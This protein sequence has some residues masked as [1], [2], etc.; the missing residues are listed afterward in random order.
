MDHW[1]WQDDAY[2]RAWSTILMTVNH[3]DEKV[4]IHKELIE[5]KRGQSLLSL[6]GW[7]KM[8]GRRWT[9]QKTRTFLNLLK[10][11]RMIELEG[12]RKTTR[13][14][15]CNYEYYQGSQQTNNRQITDIQQTD[16]RQITSNNKLKNEKND[17]NEKKEYISLP[18]EKKYN[19][20]IVLFNSITNR[21]YRG[22][23]SSRNHFAARIKDGYTIDDIRIAIT[24]AS[25]DE[26]HRET[27]YKYLTP[28]YILRSNKIEQ[29]L[30]VGKVKVNDKTETERMLEQMR[31]AEEAAKRMERMSQ[32]KKITEIIEQ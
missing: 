10:Q 12:L 1:I 19:D 30:Q 15:V 24:A 27:N 23:R 9:V 25:R 18:I 28:E 13:L 22:D 17:K 5:C 2:Y 11:D 32:T 8:F 3:K 7:T 21:E 4:L 14:T 29:W 20:F 6:P 26:Y 16:N 31:I